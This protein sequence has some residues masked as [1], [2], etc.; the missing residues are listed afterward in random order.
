MATFLGSSIVPPL[1]HFCSNATAI[2]FSRPI[3]TTQPTRCLGVGEASRGDPGETDNGLPSSLSGRTP[4]QPLVPPSFPAGFR[5]STGQ[6]RSLPAGLT[7]PR[8]SYQRP[9]LLTLE[10]LPTSTRF[11]HF[12]R[13]P[14][15]THRDASAIV[16]IHSRF[17]VVLAPRWQLPSGT[18]SALRAIANHI[19]QLPFVA[20]SSM[21][22]ID[23]DLLNSRR[24]RRS[25]Q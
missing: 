14:P 25:E 10:F 9:S 18:T 1:S 24:W 13:L 11:N 4:V 5:T 19:S 22:R 21:L 12:L 2:C 3:T 23:L 8:P 20:P 15:F 17:G 7:P 16:N 6:S